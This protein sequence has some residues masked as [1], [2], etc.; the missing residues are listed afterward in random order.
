MNLDEALNDLVQKYNQSSFISTTEGMSG[1]FAVMWHFN[2]EGNFWEF[3]DT[4]FGR[5][6]TREEAIIEAKDWAELEELEY[7]D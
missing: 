1:H 3:F 4:G 6:A 2:T 7:R 5:Y